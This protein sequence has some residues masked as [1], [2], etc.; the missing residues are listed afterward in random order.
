MWAGCAC[1]AFA[2][3]A[4]MY[5]YYVAESN[6]GARVGRNGFG[7]RPGRTADLGVRSVRLRV[8]VE[9]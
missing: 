3:G 8:E 9:C 4:A 7:H 6:A 2:S 1:A 5:S